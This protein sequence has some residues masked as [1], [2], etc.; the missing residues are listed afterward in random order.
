M[1]FNGR[2]VFVS[3]KARIGKNVRI[4]DN[5]AIYDNVEIGDNSII[6]NDTVLGEPLAAYYE[7]NS[8]ENPPTAIGA[9]SLIRSHSII[10]AGCSIG[11]G[12]SSGHRITIR[13]HCVIGEHCLVG[14]L[15]DVQRRARIGRSCKLYSSVH[16]APT[17]ILGDFVFMFPYA[18]M[19][20][21]PWPPSND[22]KGGRIGD[23]SVVAVHAVILPG[24]EVGKNCLIG[25][26]SVVRGRVPDFSLATG[27]PAKVVM[28]IRDYV[29][30]G[31]GRPYPWMK[32]FERGMP[33]EGLGFEAW[34]R[35][36]QSEVKAART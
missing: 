12:F 9:N 3:P 7:E 6:C 34:M 29:V 11:A 25:A 13:E 30:L 33:W 36:N 26:N 27:D 21:D 17:S 10:Y 16:L 18:I 2:N 20:N 28:D 22:L 8:Y 31:K 4:G 19:T 5:T 14:T 24:V 1:K 32:R 35:Q 23:F 15:C